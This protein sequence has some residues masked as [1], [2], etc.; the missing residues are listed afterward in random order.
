MKSKMSTKVC[1]TNDSEA[2]VV[3]PIDNV[4]A[5]GMAETLRIIR[6]VSVK[7]SHD[8]VFNVVFDYGGVSS[9]CI[10]QPFLSTP[11]RLSLY[12]RN[13]PAPDQVLNNQGF[14]VVTDSN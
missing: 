7:C 2:I 3:P 11:V 8:F 14:R 9:H 10:V 5:L 12:H 4:P 13:Y 1:E 6:M